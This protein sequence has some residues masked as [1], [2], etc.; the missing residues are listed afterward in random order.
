MLGTRTTG[1]DAANFMIAGPSWDGQTPKGIKKVVQMETTIGNGAMRTQLFNPDDI[2]NVLQLQEGVSVQT[3]SSFLGQPAPARSPLIAP[4][5]LTKSE[6]KGSLEIFSLLNQLLAFAPTHPSEV[7]LRKR[8]AKIGVGDGLT[9]DAAKLSP[10]IKT[11]IELGVADA[12]ADINETLQK[13]DTGEVTPGEC[14]GTRQRIKNNLYRASCIALA[15]N[16][17]P[18]EEVIYPF[19]GLDESGK[20]L[21]GSNAYTI[22]FPGDQLP[23]ARQ[24]WSITMYDGIT[25]L[26]VSN[27]IDRYLLNTPME[28]NWV[29]DADG[30]YTFYIQNGS[31]DEDK[32]ANWLPAPD[33]PFYMVM[34]LYGPS[35]AAQE[36]E[37]QAPKPRLVE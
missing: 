15:G 34:R 6:Q 29:K 10:E 36:G 32:K 4:A 13:L 11:A 26:L 18:K 9:F 17:Q 20:P 16:A 5:A 35:V 12:W 2:D 27:P 28:P 7:E 23:P 31:P 14:Y 22:T 25:R 8:V 1:N 33:G 37:W 30:G 19:I 3:L 24:F 21:N